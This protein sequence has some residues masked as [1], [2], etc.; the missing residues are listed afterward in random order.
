M[1]LVS[2]WLK[3]SIVSLPS[4]SDNSFRVVFS[5]PPKNNVLSQLPTI[6]SALSLYIAFNW[7]CAWS[8]ILADISLERIVAISFS[9]LGIKPIFANSSSKHLTCIGSL[10]PYSSSALSQSKLNSCEYII[11][12]TKL[13]VSSVSEMITNK[14]VFLSPVL[15]SSNSS[16]LI[17]F[18]NSFMSNGASLAPQEIRIDLAVLP[19]ASLYFLYC[20][21]AKWFGSFFSSASKS[22]S[23]GFIY[24]S[25]SSLTSLA[26]IMSKSVAKFCS[27]IGAS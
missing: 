2:D 14:A 4:D 8:I 9:N 16:S 1:D 24:V 13:N 10:P 27:S 6:V 12:T 17:K 15:S 25:S 11:D 18:L 5:F 19:A 23:T 7:D 21:T 20:L 3:R 22:L 26:S